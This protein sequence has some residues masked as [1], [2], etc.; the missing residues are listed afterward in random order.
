VLPIPLFAKIAARTLMYRTFQAQMLLR[1]AAEEQLETL[2]PQWQALVDEARL[3]AMSDADLGR[4]P[5]HAPLF[6]V[7]APPDRP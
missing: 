4:L 5:V 7:Q 2:Q 3:Y 1:D 6:V